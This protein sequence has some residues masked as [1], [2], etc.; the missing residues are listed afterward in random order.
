[1]N[2]KYFKYC[3]FSILIFSCFVSFGQNTALRISKL[4]RAESNL[5]TTLSFLVEDNRLE[6]FI[7][8]KE[9]C[10][11]ILSFN[12]D[13]DSLDVF[14]KNLQEDW[15][16]KTLD[17]PVVLIVRPF[18]GFK[19]IVKDCILDSKES[20]LQVPMQLGHLN[21]LVLCQDKELF[22]EVI[23]RLGL[24]KKEKLYDFEYYSQKDESDSSEFAVLKKIIQGACL[25][26]EK[27]SVLKY[28]GYLRDSESVIN[29]KFK[30]Q[31]NRINELIVSNN[32]DSLVNLE[33]QNEI[34]RLNKIINDR[35]PGVES[36]SLQGD[37][38]F[39][40]SKLSFLGQEMKCRGYSNGISIGKRRRSEGSNSSF[41]FGGG[42]GNRTLRIEQ[43]ENYQESLAGSNYSDI[44]RVKGFNEELSSKYIN[45][46]LQWKYQLNS[47]NAPI[48]YSASVGYQL[49]INYNYVVKSN[50]YQISNSRLY[51]Q[52]PTEISSLSGQGLYNSSYSYNTQL[53]GESRLYHFLS[54]GA[55][56]IWYVPKNNDLAFTAQA[57]FG[58][59]VKNNGNDIGS[60]YAVDASRSQSS[61]ILSSS[62][63]MP[64]QFAINVGLIYVMK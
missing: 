45:G 10:Y 16:D 47:S 14:Y 61:V 64:K 63:W 13:E 12:S 41:E 53:N 21:M 50:S 3:F 37:V 23:T 2:K 35:K 51:N 1:M 48:G 31:S 18:V 11:I 56:A 20:K 36:Y 25:I 62:N 44:L 33:N 26:D 42:F 57:Q 52:F 34:K 24:S 22:K 15:K 60:D 28:I 27:K 9:E 38:S 19:T 46:Y 5:N 43:N 32:R 17:L 55:E 39:Y 4:K 59:P 40:S 8:P 30:K 58:V 6:Y 54:L 29:Y 7:N 49:G